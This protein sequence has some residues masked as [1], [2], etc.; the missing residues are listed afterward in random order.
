MRWKSQEINLKYLKISRNHKR[1]STHNIANKDNRRICKFNDLRLILRRI[2]PKANPKKIATKWN[3][4]EVKTKKIN[5]Y[6]WIGSWWRQQKLCG[7][8]YWSRF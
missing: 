1:R 2:R 6:K 7:Y 5:W 4:L 3:T 8:Y